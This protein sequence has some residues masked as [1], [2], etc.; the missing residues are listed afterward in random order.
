[1]ATHHLARLGHVFWPLYEGQRDVI[2]MMF[3][4]EGQIAAV[5]LGHRRHRDH[6]VGHVDALAIRNHPA[7]FGRAQDLVFIGADD[8]QA[9]LAIIDQQP[10]ALLH[11]PEQFGMRQAHAGVIAGRRV[12]VELE[13]ARVADNGAA[14]LERADAQF[15]PLQVAQDGDRAAIFLLGLAHMRDGFG[16]GGVVAM[17]HIDAERIGAGEDELGD[18]LGRTAGRAECCQNFNLAATWGKLAHTKS[19]YRA[20]ASYGKRPRK[21]Q[22][23]MP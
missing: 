14:I 12:T 2:G 19:P 4:R 3:Q 10:L 15:W 13:M 18:H 23:P 20:C 11:D 16:M 6:R 7:D 9:Q 1:M 5:L 22:G 17:A 8:A 21:T